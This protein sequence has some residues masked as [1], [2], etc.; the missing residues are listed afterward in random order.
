MKN[1]WINKMCEEFPDYHPQS[2]CPSTV[3]GNHVIEFE[4]FWMGREAY[5]KLPFCAAC[6]AKFYLVYFLKE[7]EQS[8]ERLKSM[9]IPPH[10]GKDNKKSN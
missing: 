6:K 8:E 9:G 10:P 4:G 5:I 2:E 3:S 1:G 7:E